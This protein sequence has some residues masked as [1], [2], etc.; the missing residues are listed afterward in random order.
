MRMLAPIMLGITLLMVF[1][2]APTSFSAPH[3][4]KTSILPLD[5]Q[6]SLERTVTTMSIPEGNTLPWGFVKGEVTDH[7]SHYPVIIQFF[8]AEDMVHIA[9]VDVN[10]DGTFE[11]KFRVRYNDDAGNPVDVFEGDYTVKIFKVVKSDL[12]QI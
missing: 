3:E 9:Q 1:T 4:E 12:D 8:K 6:V 11:Y 2:F 10:G 7:A 5:E